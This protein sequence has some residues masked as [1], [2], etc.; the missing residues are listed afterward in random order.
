MKKFV[1]LSGILLA[2]LNSGFAKEKEMYI[3]NGVWNWVAA[4]TRAFIPLDVN[5]NGKACKHSFDSQSRQVTGDC[6]VEASVEENFEYGS[7]SIHTILI[8]TMGYE[9]LNV[10]ANYRDLKSFDGSYYHG[11]DKPDLQKPLF[12]QPYAMP[13]HCEKTLVQYG[14]SAVP[15][16]G[17]KPRPGGL[18]LP[19]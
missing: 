15:R 12:G 5:E 7:K 8:E 18:P 14:S 10:P 13:I 1:I 6:F 2:T 17:G 19:R 4:E 9:V 11:T 3:C 16:S